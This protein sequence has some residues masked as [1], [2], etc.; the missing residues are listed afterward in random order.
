MIVSTPITITQLKHAF[1]FTTTKIDVKICV[2]KQKLLRAVL[3]HADLAA[4]TI[5]SIEL[6]KPMEVRKRS[7]LGW[8]ISRK[9]RNIAKKKVFGNWLRKAVQKHVRH[10]S[11]R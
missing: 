4:R 11:Q 1:G 8:I 2:W 5:P 9:R 10:V 3:S 7:V 6:K